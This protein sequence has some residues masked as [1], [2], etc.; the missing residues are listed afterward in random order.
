MYCKNCGHELP[1]DAKFCQKCGNAVT[2]LSDNSSLDTSMPEHTENNISSVTPN[3]Q[4]KETQKQGKENILKR[5]INR[6]LNRWKQCKQEKFK[7]RKNICWTVVNAVIILVVIYNFAISFYCNRD[8]NGIVY[9]RYKY[10][11]EY[12]VEATNRT[13]ADIIFD[14]YST[15]TPLMG[16]S[17][18]IKEQVRIGFKIYEV[19]CVRVD[20]SILPSLST[21]KSFHCNLNS[22]WSGSYVYVNL[23]AMPKLTNIDVNSKAMTIYAGEGHTTLLSVKLKGNGE[24]ATD[25][26]FIFN[27]DFPQLMTISATNVYPKSSER[28]FNYFTADNLSDI[29]LTLSNEQLSKCMYFQQQD[30]NNQNSEPKIILDDFFMYIAALPNTH[31]EITH[32]LEDLYGTWIYR[33]S[34][35]NEVFSITLQENGYVRINDGLGIIGVDLFTFSELDNSTLLLKAE[36]EDSWGELLSFN[37]PY[38]LYGKELH[39]SIYGYELDLVNEDTAK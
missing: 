5:Y 37:M 2:P 19:D 20:E 6:Y 30:N 10:G 38:E 26:R 24:S 13:V 11:D 35:G 32:T 18:T 31:I 23:A 14:S 7:G 28:G 17:L 29:N 3:E 4:P 1:E 15:Y 12:R 33:E 27:G 22:E 16:E 25:S 39:L 21:T 8:L 36:T 9:Y 34:S